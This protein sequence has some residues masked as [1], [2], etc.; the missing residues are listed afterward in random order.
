MPPLQGSRRNFVGAIA[1]PTNCV[2]RKAF[3]GGVFVAKPNQPVSR[4]G[5]AY[6]R[7][8]RYGMELRLVQ[9]RVSFDWRANSVC[10]A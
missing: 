3:A 2:E 8:P 6:G 7:R 4:D 10:S 1:T 9:P 5:I